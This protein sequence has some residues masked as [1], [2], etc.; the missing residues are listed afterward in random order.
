MFVLTTPNR[1][2][3]RQPGIETEDFSGLT[4]AS[5]FLD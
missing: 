5:E 3:A 1:Y 2:E 4:H